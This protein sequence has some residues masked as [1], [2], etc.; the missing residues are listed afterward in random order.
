[1][2]R[3]RAILDCRSGPGSESGCRCRGVIVL[4]GALT[5]RASVCCRKSFQALAL[6]RLSTAHADAI[7]PERYALQRTLD[8]TDLLHVP[9]DL[10]QI[11]I[12]QEIGEGLVLEIADAAGDIGIGLVVG[13]RQR[14][15]RL[16]AQLEPSLPQPV[17]EG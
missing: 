8:R 13:S 9:R 17:L 7:R 4:I 12:D 16:L 1:M 6:D 10:G 14:L 3:S 15:A 2:T 5:R 11:D